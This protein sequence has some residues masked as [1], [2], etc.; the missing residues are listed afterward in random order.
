MADTM[1][2]FDHCDRPKAGCTS[3]IAIDAALE[4]I[5]D[6]KRGAPRAVCLR[7]TNDPE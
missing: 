7:R 5:V 1:N 6:F 2:D 4:Q 3:P